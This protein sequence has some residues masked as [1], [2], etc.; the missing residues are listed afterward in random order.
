MGSKKWSPTT[1]S[2]FL[3]LN[4]FK[5]IQI[6]LFYG[7]HAVLH[8]FVCSRS[9]IPDKMTSHCW[10]FWFL[11]VGHWSYLIALN[12]DTTAATELGKLNWCCILANK[13]MFAKTIGEFNCSQASI[14]QESE[15]HMQCT[16][17][18]PS[19]TRTWADVDG[20]VGHDYDAHVRPRAWG[21]LAHSS[22]FLDVKTT[23]SRFSAKWVRH[24]SLPHIAR[25]FGLTITCPTLHDGHDAFDRVPHVNDD[26]A[27]L[28][29]MP[30]SGRE[31][32]WTSG[33]H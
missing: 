21:L 3:F 28:C 32:A 24:G 9:L 2:N 7:P 22:S 20:D 33:P 14:E 17:M 18:L 13:E 4:N 6:I 19:W 30:L 29:A 25:L 11:Y 23:I 31:R 1:I 26:L 16:A 15:A 10:W 12:Q 8:L 27:L 5:C